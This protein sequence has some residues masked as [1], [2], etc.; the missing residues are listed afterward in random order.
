M[1]GNSCQ[2]SATTLPRFLQND[3]RIVM[4]CAALHNDLVRGVYEKDGRR[5]AMGKAA[6]YMG[7][8]SL[9]G[10]TKFSSERILSGRD[11]FV[12]GSPRAHEG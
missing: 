6:K 4:W 2:H 3:I 7:Y 1:S 8:K 10:R 12:A 9:R 5:H 11:V